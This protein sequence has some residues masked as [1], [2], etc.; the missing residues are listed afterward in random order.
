VDERRENL[1]EWMGELTVVEL[2]KR[3]RTWFVGVWVGGGEYPQ[4][5]H[6]LGSNG[7]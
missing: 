7:T 1:V 5:G 4:R 6:M 2:R 3:G